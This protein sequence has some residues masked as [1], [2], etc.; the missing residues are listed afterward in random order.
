MKEISHKIILYITIVSLI[1]IIFIQRGC[2]TQIEKY[3]KWVQPSINNEIAFY[4]GS[5]TALPMDFQ[6]NL[7]KLG[8][9]YLDKGWAGSIRLSMAIISTTSP[10]LPPS[11]IPPK[12]LSPR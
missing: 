10:S 8:N 1:T 11:A 2:K 7:L 3:G 6:E 4:G 12:L 9:Q 5:F